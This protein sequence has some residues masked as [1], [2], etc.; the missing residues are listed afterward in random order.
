[1][2][3]GEAGEVPAPVGSK[4]GGQMPLCLP[5][6]CALDPVHQIQYCRDPKGWMMARADRVLRG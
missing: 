1:M 4:L 3:T 6:F 5:R 2:K